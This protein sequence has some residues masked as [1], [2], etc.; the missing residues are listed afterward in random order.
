MPPKSAVRASGKNKPKPKVTAADRVRLEWAGFEAWL[1][2]QR[3]EVEVREE[4]R[5]QALRQQIE[6]KKKTIPKGF[7]PTLMKDFEEGKEKIAYEEGYGLIH[8]SRDEWERRLEKA[9]L[10]A[11]DWDPMTY[12]EQEAVRSA[13]AGFSDD[14]EEFA[15]REAF[16]AAESSVLHHKFTQ[17]RDLQQPSSY[18]GVPTFS[19]QPP[20]AER[21]K[22]LSPLPDLPDY[23]RPQTPNR[24]PPTPQYTPGHTALFGETKPLGTRYTGPILIEEN[25]SESPDDADFAKFKMSIREQMI[26]EFHEEAATLEIILVR[27]EHEVKLKPDAVKALVAG[28][29]LNME[30]L[31]RQK[32]DKRKAL[33]DAERTKRKTEILLRNK[34]PTGTQS[35]TRIEN[36]SYPK[37]QGRA[38]GQGKQPSTNEENS[39]PAVLSGE[40]STAVDVPGGSNQSAIGKKETKR[41]KNAAK[42]AK[43]APASRLQFPNPGTDVPPEKQLGGED[44][45]ENG[46]P[47]EQKTHGKLRGILKDPGPQ[48]NRKPTVEEVSDAE[49]DPRVE[50]RREVPKQQAS[51]LP[52]IF[53]EP[54]RAPSTHPFGS[55]SDDD[56]ATHFARAVPGFSESKRTKKSARG[57]S[58]IQQIE[59]TREKPTFSNGDENQSYWDIINGGISMEQ[60]RGDV[61]ESAGS[62][63]GG[64]HA[65]W[66]P[67]AFHDSADEDDGSDLLHSL[68]FGGSFPVDDV[69]SAPWAGGGLYYQNF[70]ASVPS[71]KE[72]NVVGKADPRNRNMSKKGASMRT[73]KEVNDQ[74]DMDEPGVLDGTNW[75]AAMMGKFYGLAHNSTNY[76]SMR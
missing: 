67:P 14:D 31:R 22:S 8:R 36:I 6:S 65:V 52:G 71:P 32:E 40:A 2:A 43:K 10:K 16:E 75:E 58:P 25:S 47:S 34:S 4:V 17:A 48:I 12:A 49:A 15:T 5:V 54:S 60:Q 62:S 27:K 59:T 20:D 39:A 7:H 26:R 41:Q 44:P 73:G 45:V 33:V 72:K 76:T 66:A 53:A 23:L 57:S 1:D 55:D 64:K 30:E 70:S 38:S 61:S 24:T 13:L 56:R 19:K 3:K 21:T 29:E 51:R 50:Y 63:T 18:L 37:G 69:P 68:G 28:H 42:S 74:N 11:E 46:R 9:G 35:A